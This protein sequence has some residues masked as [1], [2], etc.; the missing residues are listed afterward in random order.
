MKLANVRRVVAPTLARVVTPALAPVA[1]ERSII[2]AHYARGLEADR[3]VAD[4][5]GMLEFARTAEIIDRRLPPAPAVVADIGGG[6]GRYTVWLAGRG[7]RVE[8][9]D[10]ISL[11]VEQARA[12]ANG[13]PLVRAEVGDALD[14]DLADASVD[15]V[16]LLGPIYHLRRRAD[17]I[18]ALREALRIVRPGGP[19]FVA[20]I[21]RWAAR[22]NGVLRERLYQT[23]EG[24]IDAV[25][26]VERAGWAS[27]LHPGAFSAFCH[28]P[29]QLRAE[30][31]ASGLHVADLVSV[32]GA[33]FLL[34]D[35][36][37]R[38]ADPVD[39]EVVLE[40]LRATER[41]PEMLGVGPHLLVTAVRRE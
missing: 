37:E 11:H 6:P 23:H 30:V 15:A 33:A 13:S 31:R 21:S 10:L 27:P 18:T 19:V 36:A 41:V 1:E 17:R 7:Y 5:P 20:A 38:L 32:Q 4:G 3:L 24:F 26:T 9:R 22:L 35:L 25:N 2:E 8:H 16:L 39:R 28:R 40:C 14:L 29:A 34:G 12:S